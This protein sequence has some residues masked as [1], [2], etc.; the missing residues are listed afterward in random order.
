MQILSKMIKQRKDSIEQFKKANRQD[1]SDIEEKELVIL[2]EYLPE[3]LSEE[4]EPGI[5]II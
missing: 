1:L 4:N 2:N 3:Q 5:N